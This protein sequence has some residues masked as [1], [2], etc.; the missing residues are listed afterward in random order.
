MKMKGRPSRKEEIYK[1]FL[2]Y[3]DEEISNK[4]LFLR[5]NINKNTIYGSLS[6]LKE[7]N[8]IIYIKPGVHKL[9]PEIEVEPEEDVE[10][11][12]RSEHERTLR[13]YAALRKKIE[14]YLYHASHGFIQQFPGNKEEI[15]YKIR[16]EIK[17][18]IF[19]TIWFTID[20][21]LDEQEKQWLKNL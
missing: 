14:D 18:M 3:P 19:E 8:K 11:I 1:E 12:T 13:Q 10:T 9:N 16:D 4:L 5:L 6:K 15:T 20:L 21:Q 2:H 17:M 7:E